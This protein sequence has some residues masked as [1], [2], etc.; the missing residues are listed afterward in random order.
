MSMSYILVHYTASLLDN[1][2]VPLTHT[3]RVSNVHFRVHI[4]LCFFNPVLVIKIMDLL[5]FHIFLCLKN[6][7][8]LTTT[9]VRM[10]EDC[11]RF[12]MFLDSTGC[13][14]APCGRN[15]SS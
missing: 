5:V 12:E 2:S 9:L 8:E 10:T 11:Q 15:R 6:D 4:F 1:V 14:V 13:G 7:F 3:A